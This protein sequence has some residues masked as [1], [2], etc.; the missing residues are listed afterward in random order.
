MGGTVSGIRFGVGAIVKRTGD[1]A[2]EERIGA[3]ALVDLV[4]GAG[5]LVDRDGALVPVVGVDTA[6]G[7]AVVGSGV[8]LGDLVG[9]SGQTALCAS[10]SPV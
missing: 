3:G 10:T 5:T 4:V 2:F 6:A 7:A 8:A 1:G 9:A